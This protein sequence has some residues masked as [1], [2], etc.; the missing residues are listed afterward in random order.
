MASSQIQIPRDVLQ[1]HD[2]VPVVAKFKPLLVLYC[3]LTV[4]TAFE[5]SI[6]KSSRRQFRDPVK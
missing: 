1:F 4:R 6:E 2:S 3:V 5:M